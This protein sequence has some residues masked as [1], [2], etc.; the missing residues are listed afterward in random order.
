MG[1]NFIY[2]S[3][4]LKMFENKVLRRIFRHRKDINKYGDNYI[5]K[6]FT[7]FILHLLLLE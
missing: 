7:I 3:Q 5:I 2:Y 6:T 1:L 4:S